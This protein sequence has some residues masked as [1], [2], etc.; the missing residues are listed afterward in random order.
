MHSVAII[1]A[2]GGSKGLPRKNVLPFCGRPLIAWSIHNAQASPKVDRVVVSTDDSEIAQVSR[3]HGAEVIMRPAPLSHD[4]APSEDA[5]SHALDVLQIAQGAL[6]FLQCTA[7][8]ALP[9]D[10]DGTVQALKYADSAVT[11]TPWHGFTWKTGPEGAEPV[12][13]P[14]GVRPMRQQLAGRYREVGAVYAMRIE[15]FRRARHRFFGRIGVHVIPPERSVEIDDAT[16]FALAETL[17]RRHIQQRRA[18]MLPARI[19][20][21]VIDFDGVLTDNRVIVSETG[22]ES[23]VCHRG[24]GWAMARLR[25]AGVRILVLTNEQNPVVKRRCE[26]LGV[27]VS[28]AAGPKLP[29][30]QEWVTSEGIDPAAMLYVGNDEPDAACMLF[31]GCGVAPADAYPA[32]KRAAKIVLDT[33]G[34]SGC[35]R[36]LAEWIVPEQEG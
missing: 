20:A 16:D 26:K 30:L 10:I 31:S 3:R 9:E 18:A 25:A 28:V 29:A 8:L 33:P 15:G 24:D 32:A 22:S 27:P 5:L 6:V 4:T 36:E 1:P 12:D 35:I 7:P 34:G 19:Q 11:V 2:R 13:H 23:V 21:I 17:M 14:K